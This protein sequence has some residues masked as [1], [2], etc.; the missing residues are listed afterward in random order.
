MIGA[1][2]LVLLWN[3]TAGS[4]QSIIYSFERQSVAL[5]ILKA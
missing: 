1:I 2:R 3:S 4:E 5:N